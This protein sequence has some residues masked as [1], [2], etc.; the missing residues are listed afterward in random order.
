MKKDSLKFVKI[1][2]WYKS[3][4]N[5]DTKI[6]YYSGDFTKYHE[7][8]HYLQSLDNNFVF[9][10]YISEWMVIL[11]IVFILDNSYINSRICIFLYILFIL[12]AE[13]DAHIYTV[14][15]IFKKRCKI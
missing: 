6:I 3:L 10:K 5:N 4:Y 12:Y 14:L 2:S 8:K 1:K 7:Y 13:I 15:K 11:S 9:L